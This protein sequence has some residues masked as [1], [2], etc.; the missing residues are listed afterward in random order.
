MSQSNIICH[1]LLMKS[2]LTPNIDRSKLL[3]P[4][5]ICR[6]HQNLPKVEAT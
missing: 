2:F 3:H 5:L 1:F 4:M 6:I